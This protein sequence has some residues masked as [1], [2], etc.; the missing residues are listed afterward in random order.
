MSGLYRSIETDIIGLFNATWAHPSIPVF[1]RV[2]DLEPLPDPATVPHF[3][4][5]TIL[6]DTEDLLA[7]GGG[8]GRNQKSQNGTVEFVAFAARSLVSEDTLLDLLWDATQTVRSQRLT[9]TYAGGSDLSFVGEGN[10]F[11]VNP[12]EAG[13]WFVRG[14][15]MFFDY[16]FIG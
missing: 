13:N 1:W 15:R 6:Y 16:R 11:D 9:G 5:N 14:C 4:R 7:F 8:R 12:V 10:H 3:L 2:N